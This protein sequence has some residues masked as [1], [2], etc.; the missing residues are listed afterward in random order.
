MVN[1]L[2]VNQ[3]VTNG[4]YVANLEDNRLINIINI[5]YFIDT[6]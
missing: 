6:S 5:E 4:D 3:T 1:N 2:S